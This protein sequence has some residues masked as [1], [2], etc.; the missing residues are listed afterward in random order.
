MQKLDRQKLSILN[1]RR[2]GGIDIE[3]LADNKVRISQ[4]RLINGIILRQKDLLE[5]ARKIFPD[6]K[7]K[8]IT[9]V[10]RLQLDDINEEWIFAKMDELGIKRN[11]LLKQMAVDKSY[12]SLLFSD[13]SNKWKINLTR[14]M[15][16]AFFYFFL[17]CE[18]GRDLLEQTEEVVQKQ[19][20]EI[21]GDLWS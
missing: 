15:K 1:Y 12:L 16:T 21:S 13:K 14:A 3:V 5:R 2:Y 6:K 10:Y 18:L 7:I 11:D 19:K 4:N 8:I 17:S 9:V 20:Q